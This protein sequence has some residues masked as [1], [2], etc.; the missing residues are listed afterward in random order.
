MSY[1]EFYVGLLDREINLK[2]AI[3]KL[4]ICMLFKKRKKCI[5]IQ[6]LNFSVALEKND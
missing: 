4:F 2:P 3:N 1:S 5:D 6:E